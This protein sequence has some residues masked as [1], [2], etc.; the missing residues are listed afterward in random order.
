MSREDAP[1]FRKVEPQKCPFCGSMVVY[2]ARHDSDWGS[3][4]SFYSINEDKSLYSKVLDRWAKDPD[5][6]NHD[7]NTNYCYD[8]ST[9]ADF[10][11]VE[12]LV[13][14]VKN[15]TRESV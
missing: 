1:N 13:E 7:I 8:C 4:N 10:D 15:E 14:R 9:F 12:K 2:S 6:I 5:D 11:A 3:S